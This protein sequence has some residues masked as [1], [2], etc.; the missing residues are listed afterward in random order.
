[1]TTEIGIDQLTEQRVLLDLLV[2][3][4][5]FP[6]ALGRR[7]RIEQGADRISRVQLVVGDGVG[8][9][10]RVLCVVHEEAQRLAAH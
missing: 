6:G 1:M 10:S 5:D 2:E 4:S 7:R 9:G 8:L 3:Q